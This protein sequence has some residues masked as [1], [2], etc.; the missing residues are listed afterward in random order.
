LT[1]IPNTQV[2]AVRAHREAGLWVDKT[3]SDLD[4]TNVRQGLQV[5]LPG[6]T[7]P[8]VYVR[9]PDATHLVFRVPAPPEEIHAFL[10][11]TP[12]A[13]VLRAP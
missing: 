2:S 5:V 8:G 13:G 6:S 12:L 7:K 10:L 4:I 3:V 11:L 9:D 1:E